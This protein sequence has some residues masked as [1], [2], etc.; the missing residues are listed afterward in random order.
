MEKPK[1]FKENINPQEITSANMLEL[2]PELEPL[3]NNHESSPWHEETTLEHTG[4]V[5]DNLASWFESIKNPELKKYFSEIVEK[6]KRLDLLKIVALFHDLGKKDTLVINEHGFTTY[7]NHEPLSAELAKPIL[8]RFAITDKEK[9]YVLAIIANHAKPHHALN[10]QINGKEN[11]EDLKQDLKNISLELAA[12]CMVDTMA[13]KLKN[14]NPDN[15]AF[16]IKAYTEFL[17]Q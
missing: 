1:I 14:T 15:Y 4:S 16:R 5:I 6:N 9:D 2:A 11:L 3:K 12:F 8:E 7:P 17:N 10:D 13:S